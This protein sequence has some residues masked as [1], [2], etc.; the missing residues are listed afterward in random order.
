MLMHRLLIVAG[1]AFSSIKASGQWE[2][3]DSHTTAD[4]RGIHSI[5]GGVAWASGTNGTI[6]RTDD[7]GSVWHRCAIPPGAERLDFRGVQGI[8]SNTAVALSSGKGELSRLYRTTDGC[9]TW[10]LVLTNPD[11]E[12]FFDAVRFDLVTVVY[13]Q[14]DPKLI[15][16]TIV[17]D[18]VGGSFV[19]YQSLDAGET[20]KRWANDKYEHPAVAK[21]N[22]AIF[23]ASNSAVTVPG[24]NGPLAFVTGGAGGSRLFLAQPH[25]PFDASYWLAFTVID[26]SINA[27]PTSG[28][29]SVASR[30]P[31]NSPF[32]D[33]MIVGGDYSKPEA[34]DRT[35]IFAP[36]PRFLF[37]TRTIS[38]RVSPHGY[39][40]A[41]AYDAT[42]KAWIA[43]GP[44]GT[45][46]STDDGRNWRSLKPASTDE[47][48]ADQ[49]WNALSLPLVVGPHGRIGKLDQNALTR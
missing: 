38:P 46:I 28:A 45:D 5:S 15:R 25:S 8:D 33:L 3:Q 21:T 11:K 41:V 37:A 32:A 10:K 6:L 18:P 39:R 7:G 43:V 47:P 23:A 9:Q 31:P 13:P 16:G 36:A 17:G 48:D 20:W 29:F 42:H 40:S 34:S 1:L 24:V 19:I 4:L 44:N 2:I 49:Y 12:G 35:A 26:L 30:F 22:E 27:T 14:N